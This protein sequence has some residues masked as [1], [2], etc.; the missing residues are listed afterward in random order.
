MAGQ[1]KPRTPFFQRKA[2]TAKPR[3]PFFL[4]VKKR[5]NRFNS[6]QPTIATTRWALAHSVFLCFCQICF[7]DLEIVVGA[8]ALPAQSPPNHASTHQELDLTPYR[9]S[10]IPAVGFSKKKKIQQLA[11]TDPRKEKTS[12]LKLK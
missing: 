7:H 11:S 12:C 9:R 4:S 6:G 2:Q 1:D 8:V 5:T 10:I 3:V